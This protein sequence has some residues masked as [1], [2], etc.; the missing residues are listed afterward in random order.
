LHLICSDR[1]EDDQKTLH[2]VLGW[3]TPGNDDAS[4]ALSGRE[5]R[6]MECLEIGTIMSEERSVCRSSECQ[7]VLVSGL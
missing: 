3:M 7:L 5:I 1:S 4:M 2:N 6:Q